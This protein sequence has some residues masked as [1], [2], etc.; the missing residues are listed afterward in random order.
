ME[1]NQKVFGSNIPLDTD[2]ACNVFFNT[3]CNVA[4]VYSSASARQD[5]V[6]EWAR[7]NAANKSPTPVKTMSSPISGIGIVCLVLV[8]PT[9]KPYR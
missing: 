2:I 6:A 3:A 7:N 4:T 9:E 1:I 8:S 5:F